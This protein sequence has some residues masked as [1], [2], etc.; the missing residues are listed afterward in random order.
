M[1][2]VKYI[3]QLIYE[4]PA[5]FITASDYPSSLSVSSL[6]SQLRPAYYLLT[7]LLIYSMVELPYLRT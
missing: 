4:N 3:G 7:L 2:G 5:S 6:M 1:D